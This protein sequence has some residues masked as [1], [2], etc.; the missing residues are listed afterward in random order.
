M[1]QHRNV[2]VK[3]LNETEHYEI[4]KLTINPGGE[5]CPHYHPDFEIEV[6]LSGR[7]LCN[8]KPVK[9]R[10]INKWEPNT[11]HG[12]KNESDEK[13]EVLCIYYGKWSKDKEILV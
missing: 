8:E 3:V 5:I 7:L 6:I 10:T 9:N 2:S 12:Y 11:V 4:I 13:V 1:S